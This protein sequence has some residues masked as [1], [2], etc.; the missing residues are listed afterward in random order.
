MSDLPDPSRTPQESR[1]SQPANNILMRFLKRNPTPSSQAIAISNGTQSSISHDNVG[2]LR[3]HQA[4]SSPVRATTSVPNAPGSSTD[5]WRRVLNQF[6]SQVD[7]NTYV[8]VA[9][10]NCVDTLEGEIE[11]ISPRGLYSPT[12]DIFDRVRP[13]VKQLRSASE[14]VSVIAPTSPEIGAIIWGSV[15][16]IVKS[17]QHD[18]HTVRLVIQSLDPVG[19]D[20]ER[21]GKYLAMFGESDSLTQATEKYYGEVIDLLGYSVRILSPPRYKSPPTCVVEEDLR[22]KMTRI[23]LQRDHVER[24]AKAAKFQSDEKWK[25]SHKSGVEGHN[26]TAPKKAVFFFDKLENKRFSGRVDVL[27]SLEAELTDGDGSPRPGVSVLLHGLGGVGKSEIAI[28]FIYA[29]Q[30][31]YPYIFWFPADSREK[32]VIAISNACKT[33]GVLPSDSISDLKAIPLI[34]R[35]W[36]SDNTGWLI[37][38]DNAEQHSLLKE[39]WPRSNGGTIII[40][41]RHPQIGAALVDRD[42]EIRPMSIEESKGLLYT[43]LPSE[44]QL[45]D[46][47]D[48]REVEMVCKL[49]DGLPLAIILT[50]GLLRE[51]RRTL[52]ETLQILE[53]KRE[54]LLNWSPDI[55]DEDSSSTLTMLWEVN[56]LSL[57][58][59]ALHL[60]QVMSFLDP[61][62]IDEALLVNFET[63]TSHGVLPSDQSRFLHSIR[64]LFNH[65]MVRRDVASL[66]IHRLVQDVTI[67]RMSDA[68]RVKMFNTAVELVWTVFPRQSEEG[69][70]MSSLNGKCEKL[71]PH[72]ESLEARFNEFSHQAECSSIHLAEI[73]H[74]CSWSMF[75]QG[76]FTRSMRM[77]STGINIA[78]ASKTETRL[79][80]ADLLTTIAGCEIEATNEFQSAYEGLN[81]ALQLRLEAS[82]AGLIDPSHPQIANSYMSLGVAALGIGLTSRAIELGEKSISLRAARR[83]DQIQMLAMSYHN[84]A[85]AALVA[86]QLEKAKKSIRESMELSKIIGKSM[87]PEQKLAMDS[88][89]Y[90]CL[91]NIFSACGMEDEAIECQETALIRRLQSFGESHPY[92]G[93]SYW[94]LGCLYEST[95]WIKAIASF[96]KSIEIYEKLYLETQQGRAIHRLGLLL[97]LSQQH[98]LEGADQLAKARNIYKKA[99][100]NELPEE[101]QE[102]IESYDALI[103]PFYR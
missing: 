69:L 83:E 29:H 61:D 82:E 81:K 41:S 16:F 100:S 15:S 1:I 85:I 47:T 73:A 77:A 65:S 78:N 75:E 79:I 54:L 39:F 40:T 25:A 102:A 86:G 63:P 4:E 14:V 57:P 46:E 51:T 34:W 101:K 70:L 21:F 23:T 93:C 90:Y 37:V 71:L 68:E 5:H 17:S 91:G 19:R 80:Q 3:Q 67:R 56:I 2:S 76:M 6:R 33:I 95:D 22:S 72:V 30:N 13:F 94:K 88:R 52:Q 9:L 89:T 38:F 27:Q 96:R 55:D 48:A 43:L 97:L 59:N 36:L 99:T 24:E 32:L 12:A 58:A 7:P 60:L 64:Y 53:D 66:S 20:F 44:Y 18:A 98:Q 62:S 11:R 103:H 74:S 87:S 31:L 50:A 92:V 49:V 84:V 28:K 10:A 42:H 45:R 35:E 8:Q 26:L